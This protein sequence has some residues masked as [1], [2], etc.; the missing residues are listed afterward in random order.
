MKIDEF[1]Q[2][3]RLWSGACFALLLQCISSFKRDFIVVLSFKRG[4][5]RAP[6]EFRTALKFQLCCCCLQLRPAEVRGWDQPPPLGPPRHL[7]QGTRQIYRKE[8]GKM[9]HKVNYCGWNRP[10][11]LFFFAIFVLKETTTEMFYHI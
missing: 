3:F 6:P 8:G 7:N 4:A 10:Q 9:N 5:K 2:C 1:L 11:S